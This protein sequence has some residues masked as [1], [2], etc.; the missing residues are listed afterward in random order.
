[1]NLKLELVSQA[2]N[3]VSDGMILGVGA[4]ST[5][6][7]FVKQLLEYVQQKGIHIKFVSASSELNSLA[8]V[9][10]VTLLEI[11]NVSEVDLLVD[12]ADYVD[13]DRSLV[14]KGNGGFIFNELYLAS[15]AKS[16]VILVDD[17]KL[18]FERLPKIFLEVDE[19]MIAEVFNELS[20][21]SCFIR[22]KLS[23][24]GNLVVEL[25]VENADDLENFLNIDKEIEGV[26]AC[27][28]VRNFYDHVWI[29]RENDGRV[30]IDKF[31][32]KNDR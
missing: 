27:G 7:L 5:V 26:L 6:E 11:E 2:V 21:Y 23:E 1:M 3:M 16:S 22:E 30:V 25:S 32:L 17:S 10:G 15:Q 20:E 4:G 9:A 12:G 14:S 18:N 8:R 19:S 13:V 31:N 29:A 24:S 28:V